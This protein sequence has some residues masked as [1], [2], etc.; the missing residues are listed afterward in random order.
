LSFEDMSVVYQVRG[1]LESLAAN[2]VARQGRVE[3][4]NKF[5][6]IQKGMEQ[7][8]KDGNMQDFHRL[9]VNF[10]RLLST[11]ANNAYLS[12]LLDTVEIA[13]RRFGTSSLSQERMYDVIH[14]H[15]TIIDAMIAGDFER[16]GEAA[17]SH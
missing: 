8:T 3:D 10:H 6:T 14:E 1:S 4:L 9:N 2:F 12:R 15:Q 11:A 17:A 7:A 5:V 16:A 13:I